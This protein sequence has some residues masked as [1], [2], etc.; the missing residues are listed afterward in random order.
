MSSLPVGTYIFHFAVDTSMNG[1]LDFGE[2]FSD[3]VVVNIM[4]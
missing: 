2:L 3:S 1:V 4:P